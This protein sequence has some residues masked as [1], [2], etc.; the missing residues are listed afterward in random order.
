MIKHY[1]DVSGK[2]LGGWD[3]NPPAGA[4]EVPCAPDDY[5]QV[6]DGANWSAPRLSRREIEELRLR[7]YA[8]PITGSDRFKAEADA[9]RLAGNEEAALAAEQKLLDRREQIKAENPWPKEES[10]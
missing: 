3:S 5:R 8:D 9:E 1:I 6:W 7:S 10:K 4:K 2:Y